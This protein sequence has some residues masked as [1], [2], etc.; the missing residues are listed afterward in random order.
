MSQGRDLLSRNCPNCGANL[1]EAPPGQAI[2][3]RYCGHRFETQPEPNLAPRIIVIAPGQP[4]PGSL[5]A[6]GRRVTGRPLV[7]ALFSVFVLVL[8]GATSIVRSRSNTIANLPSEI[9]AAA[10]DAVF[11]WDAVAGPPVPAA[12]GAGGVEGFVG[13]IRMRGDDTLWI[14]AFEGAKLGQVWKEGPLGTYSQ[15]Y[16][17]TFASV[18][19]RSVVVTDYRAN[20]HVYDLGTGRETRTV[21]LSDRAKGMCTPLGGRH[22]WLEMSDEK[23]VLVDVDA[24]TTTPAAR[25]VGCP[26]GDTSGDCRGWLTRGAP[27]P[28]CAGPEGAPKVSGFQAVNVIEDGDAAV[29]LGKKHPGTALPIVV[30]FDPKTKSVRWQQPVASGDQAAAAESSSTSVM[31][32]LAGGRFVVPYE[33][34]GKGWHFTAFDAHTGQRI[35]DFPLH[36]GIGLDE[37]QGFSLSATRV[38]VMRSSSL[39]V[40]DAKTGAPIGTVGL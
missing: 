33:M 1:G 18:V 35:W 4:R 25:P 15:A 30:G 22:V 40:Y 3:C 31:D 13:R 17:S 12:V 27:R 10:E 21:K 19:G 5:G 14:A 26:Q 32:A 2:V 7:S 8:V 20:M 29:A 39:E 28:G 34:T 16:Q 24:G 11:M 9:V 6:P 38:Y 37:P 36:S 23:N